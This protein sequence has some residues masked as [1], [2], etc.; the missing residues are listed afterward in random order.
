MQILSKIDM[1]SY[2]HC[3]N[4]NIKLMEYHPLISEVRNVDV[5]I[6]LGGLVNIDTRY[7]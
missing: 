2:Y 4:F 1:E 6:H 7:R 5:G 3:I